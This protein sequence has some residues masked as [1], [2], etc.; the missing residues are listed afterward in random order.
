MVRY[1]FSILGVNIETRIDKVNQL[2]EVRW[3]KGLM[4][5]CRRVPRVDG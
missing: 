5:V 2:E 4:N 1:S 3:T